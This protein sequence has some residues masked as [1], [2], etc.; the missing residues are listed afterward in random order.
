MCCLWQGCGRDIKLEF[1]TCRF[2]WRKL[3]RY[4]KQ[5]L[6]ALSAQRH[7]LEYIVLTQKIYAWIEEHKR[8]NDK[9]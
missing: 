5:E 8:T 2:H 9:I 6:E 7:S 4:L 3:P 1:F